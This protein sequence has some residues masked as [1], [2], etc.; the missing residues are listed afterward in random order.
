MRNP[1][2]LEQAATG[3]QIK[4][5]LEAPGCSHY[6]N[7]IG[8]PQSDLQYK[9]SWVKCLFVS[10][11]LPLIAKNRTYHLA[12]LWPDY[13]QRLTH[14]IEP[15]REKP[16]SNISL[17]LSRMIGGSVLSNDLRWHI[18]Q[19]GILDNVDDVGCTRRKMARGQ[20]V[21]ESD[22]KKYMD[23]GRVHFNRNG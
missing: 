1:R 9:S 7:S 2:E 4:Q 14:R 11:V 20:A 17:S 15:H 10:E 16:L 18:H 6:R 12:M 23:G 5:F 21:F 3:S 22:L 13:P 19:T 8:D